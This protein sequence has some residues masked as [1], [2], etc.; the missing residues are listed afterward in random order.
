MVSEAGDFVLVHVSTPLEVCEARDLKGLY[1]KARAG[2]IGSFTGISDPYE[3][4]DDADLVID[5]SV[6]SAATRSRRSRP[7]DEGGWLV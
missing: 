1:A 2:V 6:V 5:T 3:E 7:P 4:P